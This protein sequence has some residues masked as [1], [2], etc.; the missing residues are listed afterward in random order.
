AL[1]GPVGAQRRPSGRLGGRLRAEYREARQAERT[2]ATYESW[3]DEPVTQVA[4]AWVLGTVLGR[5]CEDNGL[6]EWPLFAGPAERLVDAE[7][8]HEKY[9]REHPDRDWL[10]AAF[11]H[12]TAAGLFDRRH[13]PL[14]EIEPSFEAATALLAF[15]RHRGD[16]GDIAGR[17]V[18]LPL[19]GQVYDPADL[20]G[21]VLYSILAIVADFNVDLLRART[22]EGMAVA[23]A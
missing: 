21:K 10:T 5:F 3:R 1:A 23:R 7:E 13:N 4:A 14:W 19:G 6:I 11:E 9:F 20:M 12:P 8:R 17:G 15:W 16:D 22:R 2:A 18:K